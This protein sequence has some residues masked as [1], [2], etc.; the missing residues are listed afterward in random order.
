MIDHLT[1]STTP[2]TAREAFGCDFYPRRE[3]EHAIARAVRWVV[4][5]ALIA[6]AGICIASM[7]VACGGTTDD[8]APDDARM[9]HPPIDCS[10]QPERCK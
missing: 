5:A 3:R 1:D 2:R 10:S 4:L 6:L 8:I 7:F 9:T